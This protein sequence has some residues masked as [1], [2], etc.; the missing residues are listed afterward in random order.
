MVSAAE[1]KN[2]EEIKRS[3]LEALT[4]KLGPVGMVHF[5]RLFD[6]GKG[7]FTQERAGMLEEIEKEEILNFLK[8]D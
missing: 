3:G 1:L 4:E 5:I 7:D 8:L 2:L 6:N